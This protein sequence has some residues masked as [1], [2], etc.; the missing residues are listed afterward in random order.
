M[1]EYRFRSVYQ[2]VQTLVVCFIRHIDTVRDM[3]YERS[4]GVEIDEMFDEFMAPQAKS[5][6]FTT[7]K[8]QK[9]HEG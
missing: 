7:Y 1:K 8:E 3:E 4:Y 2:L 6:A 9:K 5:K